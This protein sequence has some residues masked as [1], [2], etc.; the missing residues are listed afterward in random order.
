MHRLPGTAV[1]AALTV[2]ASTVPAPVLSASILS[3]PVLPASVLPAPVAPAEAAHP[4]DRPIRLQAHPA[5]SETTTA[6]TAEDTVRDTARDTAE[7]TARG[8]VRETSPRSGRQAAFAEAARRYGVPESVLLAVSYL[9]SRWEGHGG[10][11]S[12]SAGYGPM[13]LVDGRAEPGRPHGAGEDPRG[14][15]TRPRVI[16]L[17]P[18]AADPPEDTLRRAS[19]LTGLPLDRLREDTSANI[20]GGAALLADH[21]R[22]TGGE[23]PGDDPA[24]WYD[25][26]ARYPGAPEKGAAGKEAALSFADE[27]YATIRSGAA[28]VTDDGE[29]VT[30]PA[31]PDLPT[32][33]SHL[34][35]ARHSDPSEPLTPAR[36][37]DPSEPLTSARRPGP[38][39]LTPARFSR[40][41]APRPPAKLS[42]PSDP[43]EPHPPE[44]RASP[45]G[46]PTAPPAPAPVTPAPSPAPA[47]KT[48]APP[49]KTA[50]MLTQRPA[51]APAP[52]PGPDCPKN[53]SCEWLPAA[54]QRLPGGGYGNHDRST[55]PRKIDYIVIHDGETSYDAMTRLVKNPAYLSWHFT[56][57][58]ADGHIAQHLRARDIGWHAGNWYVNS[59]SIGLEHEGYL[60]RGG[61]WFTEAMYLASARL[62][63]HLAAKYD[64]PLDRAHIL[65][66]DNVPG[67]TP[68]T[69]GGMH[70]DPGPYWDWAHYFELLGR[71][72]RASGGDDARSVLIRPDYA[73]NSPGFTGCAGGC[74]ALGAASVWLR[75]RPSPHRAAGQG[76]RQAPHRRLHVQRLRP[77]RPRLHRP[78]V[79]A[80]RA[81]GRLDRDLVPRSEGL[82]PRSGRSPHL[83]TRVRPP[84]DAQ[85]GPLPGQGV[86]QGVSEGARLP[87]GRSRTGPGP[88]A[89]LDTRRAGVQLGRDDAGLVPQGGRLRP[90]RAPCRHGR[91]P[92]PA[93]PVRAPD[94]VRPGLRRPAGH[95]VRIFGSPAGCAHPPRGGARVFTCPGAF[96]GVTRKWLSGRASPCQGEGRGF[97]SRLP[98]RRVLRGLTGG[99]AERRGNGLQSRLHGFKSRLHLNARP[100]DPQG[101]GKVVRARRGNPKRIRGS[102]SVV[103]H[104]LAKVRVAGSNPVFRSGSPEDD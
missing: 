79:R 53:V 1:V 10:L 36:H 50:M 64:I 94:H 97:E 83:R 60:A 87:G 90:V 7:D 55:G 74:R 48:P 88:A 41:S 29:R 98:L 25:A 95:Q 62:V 27:V 47:A 92:L 59:R 22:R 51:P 70:D 85:A 4:G 58:S 16:A 65:G 101:S 103:E 67:T 13:H 45:S 73:T 23:G 15:E 56:I 40:P 61:A 68:E 21:R 38:T 81:Q 35:P 28:R 14:D 43:R 42:G 102:G 5:P 39:P 89:V 78:A 17:P 93:D 32:P 19:E 77:R 30:L 9:E 26:V 96:P 57:R 91:D 69:V 66:H 8:T 31:T 99:V 100:S 34:T 54:Y 86:R 46:P 75:T 11:P 12:V 33:S 82:V 18:M 44:R 52:V 24:S 37:S 72:L 104:H 84:G 76:R 20:M 2:L 63:R 49:A 3:A 80:R 71:P 6:G